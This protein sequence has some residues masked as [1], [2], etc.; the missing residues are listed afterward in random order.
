M[1]TNS[2]CLQTTNNFTLEHHLTYKDVWNISIPVCLPYSFMFVFARIGKCNLQWFTPFILAYIYKDVNWS[3]FFYHI[4]KDI[5]NSYT[6]H[7]LKNFTWICQEF[8][9]YSLRILTE[10][11]SDK[12]LSSPIRKFCWCFWW[13]CVFHS[14]IIFGGLS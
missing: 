2:E 6:Y 7:P 3:I 13:D 1:Y 12:Q 8:Q 14:S 5:F 9:I 4:P 11:Q 10:F